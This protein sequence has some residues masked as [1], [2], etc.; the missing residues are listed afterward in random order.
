[1]IRKEAMYRL[2]DRRNLKSM[3]QKFKPNLNLKL[4][5]IHQLVQAQALKDHPI[6]NNLHRR[7]KNIQ[8]MV[9]DKE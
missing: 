9:L 2:T 8:S 4:L 3:L 1:M 5:H 6:Q 7:L